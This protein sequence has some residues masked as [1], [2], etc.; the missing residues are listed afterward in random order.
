MT[1][2]LLDRRGLAL[3]REG[4]SLALFLD[5]E[6]H[7]SVPLHLVERV[8]MRSSVRLD[9]GLLAHLA[10]AGIGVLMLG[11]R[12]GRKQA[13]LSGALHNDAAR[14]I[15]QYRRYG[16]PEWRAQ[17]ARR[18]IRHKLLNQLRLL[19]GA[20]RGRPDLRRPLTAAIGRLEQ[21]LRNLAGS[22]RPEIERMRG[23]EGAAA[24]AYFQGFTRL[25][26]PALEFH[27]RNRRPPKDPVNSVLSLG[28]T[29]LHFEAVQAV[30]AAGLDP[31]IGFYHEL[32]FGRDS[33]A[34]DLIEPLRPKVDAWAWDQFR[35]RRLRGEDFIR[36]GEACLLGKAGRKRFFGA[37]ERFVRPRRRWLRR[38]AG[39]LA[40]ALAGAGVEDKA[41]S[42]K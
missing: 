18:L 17:W 39:K 13:V 9:S 25:F 8:V 33:L 24:A 4:G 10:D 40:A 37:F 5:G 42:V 16:E 1:T 28:Y 3:K 35:E 14:R 6:R 38:L 12:G 32:A 7:G 22:D 26:A 23:I 41:V 2:L 11:G 15:G 30:Y 31:L 36:D 21:A 19:R 27:G 34:A 20:A 29:L